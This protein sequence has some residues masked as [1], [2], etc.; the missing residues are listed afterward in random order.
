MKKFFIP[1][2]LG[3]VLSV[4]VQAGTQTCAETNAVITSLGRNFFVVNGGA[5][6]NDHVW[7]SKTTAF[8]YVGVPA[9]FPKTGELM[10][11][12][13]LSDP[14]AGCVASSITFKAA[15]TLSCNAPKGAAPSAGKG[16]VTAVGSNYLVIGATYVNFAPC[17][18]MNYGGNA[19][20]PAVGDSAE[21]E[22]YIETSGNVMAQV[23]SF[24]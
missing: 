6:L 5:T 23:L 11:F 2:I 10:D 14:Y 7:F 4:S 21:W 17:T 3:I 1:L 13:G 16:V 19:T 22:G 20:T 12:V 15:P 18:S 24:N 9:T 8:S